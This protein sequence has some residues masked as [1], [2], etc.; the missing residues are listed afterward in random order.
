MK[1]MVCWNKSCMYDCP[2]R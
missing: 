1:I 2:I